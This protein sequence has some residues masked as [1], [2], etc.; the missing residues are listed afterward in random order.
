VALAPPAGT[1]LAA[2]TC[3]CAT[4]VVAEYCQWQFKQAVSGSLQSVAPAVLAEWRGPV[5]VWRLPRPPTHSHA[6][7][8]CNGTAQHGRARG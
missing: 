6:G 8:A 2:A 5:P 1:P 4:Q 7:S 3:S